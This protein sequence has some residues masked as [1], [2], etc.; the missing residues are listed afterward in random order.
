[1]PTLHS[2]QFVLLFADLQQKHKNVT[3]VIIQSEHFSGPNTDILQS[4]VEL[5]KGLQYFRKTGGYPEAENS[6]W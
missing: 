2:N 5:G 3:D 6:N 1:M 4:P